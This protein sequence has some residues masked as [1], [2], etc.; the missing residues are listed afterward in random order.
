MSGDSSSLE[1]AITRAADLLERTGREVERRASKDDVLRLEKVVNRL[2]D[3]IEDNTTGLVIRLDR[4]E[5]RPPV[6]LE[7]VENRVTALEQNAGRL[8]WGD[9]GKIMGALALLLGAFWWVM[10]L[11]LI[12]KVQ[13]MIG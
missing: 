11:Y 13:E 8:A 4:I 7:G 2:V 1:A 10:E 9:L 6:T 3:T 5:Q 12:A